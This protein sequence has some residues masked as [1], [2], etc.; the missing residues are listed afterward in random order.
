MGFEKYRAGTPYEEFEKSLKGLSPGTGEIYRAYLNEFFLF[1][2]STAEGFYQWIRSLEASADM[3]DRKQLTAAFEVFSASKVDAGVSLNTVSN[4]RKA[5]HKF[6]DANELTIRIKTNG[7]KPKYRGQDIVTRDQI[8]RLVEYAGPNLRLRAILLV[9]KDS[10][11]G[12]SEAAMLTVE[13]YLSA[14]EYK[15]EAGR[16]FKQWANPLIRAKTGEICEVC[17]G[18][19]SIAAIEDYRGTRREG[20]LF[21]TSKGQPHK[22]EDGTMTAEAG[23]TEKG[24]PMTP[25]SITTTVRHHCKALKAKGYKVSAHSFRKLFETSF[26]LEGKLSTAKLVMGKA[27][28]ASDE[29]YLKLGGNLIKSYAEVYVKHLLLSDEARELAEL[30]E[31]QAQ[32]NGQVAELR[33]ELDAVKTDMNEYQKHM[34][35]ALYFI[36]HL[37]AED[38]AKIVDSIKAELSG[39]TPAPD[40]PRQVVFDITELMRKSKDKKVAE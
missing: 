27:I 29:P 20:A 14:K 25:S 7:K 5:I 35:S 23:F 3:R 24:A 21:L 15:D 32:Q 28:P 13:D 33:G 36:S 6:L 1:N 37:S 22:D 31:K 12:V 16:R 8:R 38:Q 19:E 39:E 10:G 30:K 34:Q 2:D 40:Q 26:E 17:L 9:L 4:Y 11:L 18:P